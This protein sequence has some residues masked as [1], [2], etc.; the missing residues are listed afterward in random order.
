M[1]ISNI[2]TQTY[3][4]YRQECSIIINED[5]TEKEP[6]FINEYGLVIPVDG[7]ILIDHCD[8]LI[9]I[10]PKTNTGPNLLVD[11]KNFTIMSKSISIYNNL[12]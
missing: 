10:C 4:S 2:N 3:N 11:R 8:I 9:A 12:F 5:L 1:L 7:E 6:V